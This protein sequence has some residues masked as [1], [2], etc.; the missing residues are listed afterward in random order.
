MMREFLH[1]CMGT[2]WGD[3][4]KGRLVLCSSASEGR[5]V[6]LDDTTGFGGATSLEDPTWRVAGRVVAAYLC[7][8]F[9]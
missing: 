5:L 3:T 8:T 7:L 2:I 1:E 6:H 4:A 9:G